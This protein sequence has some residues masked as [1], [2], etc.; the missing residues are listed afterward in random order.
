MD[1]KRACD[2][3]VDAS[4]ASDWPPDG[5]NPNELELLCANDQMITTGHQLIDYISLGMHRAS[6]VI[7]SDVRRQLSTPTGH[8]HQTEA[9]AQRKWI[10]S[11]AGQEMTLDVI[12]IHFECQGSEL[13]QQQLGRKSTA[14][15]VLSRS[16]VSCRVTNE[17]E[18]K[19]RHSQTAEETDADG[20]K[21]IG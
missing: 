16:D 14:S 1:R 2:K 5:R 11:A 6:E 20:D 4:P 7:P 18:Q 19:P 17:G 3:P 15:F 8:C 21:T 13:R 12:S 10:K 9:S